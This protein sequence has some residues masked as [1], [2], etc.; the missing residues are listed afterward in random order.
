M[1]Q[2]QITTIDLIRH[3]ECEGTEKIF[4]GRT[5]SPLSEAGWQQMHNAVDGID[6]RWQRVVTSPLIRCQRFA[7]SLADTWSLPLMVEKGLQELDFGEWDGQSISS[8]WDKQP[9]AAKTFYTDPASCVH[10]GES[11]VAFQQRVMDS[12]QQIINDHAGERILMV[13]HGGTLRVLIAT[14]LGMPLDKLAT[15]DVPYAC[16][17]RIRIFHHDDQVLPVLLFHNRMASIHES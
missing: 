4:R 12:W 6:A 10:G 3:G 1:S 11:L 5:D 9:Q 17:S 13:I 7:A 8:V 14:M 16:L 2:Q 15:I